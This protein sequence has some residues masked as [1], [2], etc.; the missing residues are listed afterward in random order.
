MYLAG[1]GFTGEGPGWGPDSGSCG[2]AWRFG[3]GLA[4][5]P[6]VQ[7]R[8]EPVKRRWARRREESP[9]VRAQV[10]NVMPGCLLR[11]GL[12]RLD[13]RVL[14][15]WDNQWAIL[16]GGGVAHHRRDDGYPPATAEIDYA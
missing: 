1:V 16:A 3:V 6:I 13:D 14:N 5:V 4:D 2:L 7:G 15:E 8:V 9:L 12:G 10:A 11:L